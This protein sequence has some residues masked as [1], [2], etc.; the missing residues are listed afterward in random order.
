MTDYQKGDLFT[1]FLLFARQLKE[2]GLKITPARVTDAFRSLEYID[3]SDRRDFAE[4]LKANFVS[5]VKE[6]AVF[7]EVFRY[8]WG[9]IGELPPKKIISANEGPEG[10]NDLQE[11]PLA[12]AREDAPP[13][14]ER[15]DKKSLSTGYS[16]Q[17]VF[18]VKDFNKYS[19]KDQ[20]VLEKETA[21]LISRWVMKVSRRRRSASKGRE[22]DFR[23][24]IRKT[25]R[26]G[27]EILELAR[28]QR[29]VKP[30]KIISLC[31]VSGSME[32][33]T[34]FT[35]QFIFGL[36]KAF[37][38]SE[39][40]VFSTRLTRVTEVVKK[41]QGTNA[42]T[43][44]GRRV[45]DWSGGTR[46]GPCLKTFNEV[47]GKGMAAGSAVVILFSDGWDRGD[48]ALL[49]AEMKRLKRRAHRII[50][51][52]PLLGTPGY[53]PLTQG[54]QTALPYIDYFLPANDLKSFRGLG[55]VLAEQLG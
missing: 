16:P 12:A 15:S 55:E 5:S 37:R 49:E 19:F 34:R 31:D 8:Y 28:R 32:A 24:T 10:N 35:L 7:S 46:L 42:L 4:T 40:F 52:N 20:G 27:G 50:W 54:M 45:Q 6:M 41:N 2:R 11:G 30:L 43:L 47:W 14:A 21:R 1:H 26:N 38:R 51:M 18:L 53:R 48:P 23:R 22:M 36:Q 25:V 17:E 29:K 13:P 3:L 44:L 9:R 39:A 33:S